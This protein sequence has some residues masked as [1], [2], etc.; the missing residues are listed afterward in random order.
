MIP[1][2]TDVF[3][4]LLTIALFV[5]FGSLRRR[6]GGCSHAGG[7]DECHHPHLLKDAKTRESKHA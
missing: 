5:V 4:V 6:G 3:A 2:L 1:D 7:C